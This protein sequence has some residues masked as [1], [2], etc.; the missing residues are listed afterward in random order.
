MQLRKNPNVIWAILFLLLSGFFFY[1]ASRMPYRADVVTA[2]RG[3][4]FPM[5]L[6]CL[7]ALLSLLLLFDKKIVNGKPLP[8]PS[9]KQLL[10]VIAGMVGYIA[11]LH[12]VGFT[13]AALCFMVL[14]SRVLGRVKWLESVLVSAGMV[15]VIHLVFVVWLNVR[16]PADIVMMLFQ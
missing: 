8:R 4:F 5:I 6:S 3:G 16:F 10:I 11:L 7:L 15:A 2:V 14:T 1:E 9:L 13:I 12:F